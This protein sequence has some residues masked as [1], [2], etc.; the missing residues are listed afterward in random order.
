MEKIKKSLSMTYVVIL[1]R[2]HK[3][4]R[5][6]AVPQPC[7]LSAVKSGSFPIPDISAKSAKCHTGVRR[8]GSNFIINVKAEFYLQLAV[9]V[10][11]Y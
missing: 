7:R 5:G 1:S 8:S 6:L 4:I 10:Y 3:H 2:S 11:S 9:F